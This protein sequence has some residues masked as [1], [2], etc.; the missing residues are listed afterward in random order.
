[1]RIDVDMA[2]SNDEI[3]EL[4]DSIE[5]L[6]VVRARRNEPGARRVTCVW[7]AAPSGMRG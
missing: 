7:P 3:P 6:E 5:D 2:Y 4:F 1:M